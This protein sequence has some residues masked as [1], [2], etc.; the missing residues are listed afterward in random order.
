VELRLGYKQTEVGIIPED[1]EAAKL[2]DFVSLQRGHD[3]TERNRRPGDV[4][5]MGSAG[6]NG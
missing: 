5:V 6:K 2:G 4:P 1:W 3:L